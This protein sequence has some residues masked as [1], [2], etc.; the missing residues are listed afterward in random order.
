MG[1]KVDFS[2]WKKMNFLPRPFAASKEGK[3]VKMGFSRD[4]SW[5]L[6]SLENDVGFVLKHFEIKPVIC[7]NLKFEGRQLAPQM[8]R[9][10]KSLLLTPS[11]LQLLAPTLKP[12]LL[13]LRVSQNTTSW[14]LADTS[15]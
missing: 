2:F 7:S 6:L 14:R 8:I 10:L 1:E 3:E 12:P 11:K 15:I 13:E 5:S 4:K 9:E